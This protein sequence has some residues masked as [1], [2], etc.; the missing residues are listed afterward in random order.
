M[1]GI[2]VGG[3][4]YDLAKRGI[5]YAGLKSYAKDNG[6]EGTKMAWKAYVHGDFTQENTAMRLADGIDDLN[7]VDKDFG[8][9]EKGR[10]RLGETV[11]N[12]KGGR[13]I[14]ITD[15]GD[16][17]TMSV[18]LGHEAY[19]DGVVGAN[20]KQETRDA[21]LAHTKMAARMREENSDFSNSF[22]GLDLAAYDRA[23]STGNMGIMDE[24]ADALYDSSG[25]YLDVGDIFGLVSTLGDKNEC[26]PIIARIISKELHG[27]DGYNKILAEHSKRQPDDFS[28]ENRNKALEFPTWETSFLSDKIREAF[29]SAD[30]GATKMI[31]EVFG[32]SFDS[33]VFELYEYVKN[34]SLT[35]KGVN[36]LYKGITF[37]ESGDSF[38][39]SDGFYLYNREQNFDFFAKTGNFVT[40]SLFVGMSGR[41]FLSQGDKFAA[42]ISIK[43]SGWQLFQKNTKDMRMDLLFTY[44]F[45]R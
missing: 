40:S 3:A 28:E 23:L 10:I 13:T 31:N 38:S 22:V 41:N 18:V 14:S 20:N 9:D 16:L 39:V 6:E 33:K 32:F 24:Y 21:V 45:G 17:D 36:L 42:E 4:V 37:A 11:S 43:V 35:M 30:N 27:E 7:F 1:G 12:G 8:L 19:R 29:V 15:I 25:D 44:W 2:D 5:D 26:L 34:D